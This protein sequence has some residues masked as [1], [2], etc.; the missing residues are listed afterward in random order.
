[1][2]NVPH[3]GIDIFVYIVLKI[4]YEYIYTKFGGIKY[5]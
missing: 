1:M 2:R 4:F 5:T 3:Y